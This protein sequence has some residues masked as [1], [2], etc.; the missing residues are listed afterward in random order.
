MNEHLSELIK[1]IRSKIEIGAIASSLTAVAIY[2]GNFY[3][4][5]YFDYYFIDSTDI[6]IPISNSVRSFLV[7]MVISAVLVYM[8]ASVEIQKK[9]SFWSA[10]RDNAPLFV[11]LLLLSSWAI[12]VY[13]SNVDSLSGWLSI[14]LKDESMRKQNEFATQQVVTFLKWAIL[15]APPLIASIVVLVLSAKKFSFS[16]LLMSRSVGLRGAA[17]ILYLF[18]IL[19]IASAFG[20]LVG[21][22]EFNGILRKPTLVITLT[23][24]KK[25]QE[26]SS[27]YLLV[28]SEGVFYISARAISVDSKLM[29]WQV[30]QSA[31]KSIEF[32]SETAKPI[33]F[34]SVMA[35]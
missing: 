17:L 15:I 34:P 12:L 16:E 18:L 33:Q 3:Y 32:Y 22:L 21:F 10:L 9:N 11:L 5:S 28:K 30:P 4:T 31:I 25:F 14:A 1:F 19:S 26:G 29:T 6:A 13:W 23:D 7:I 20:K 24:G 27:L 35:Q 2:F 8:V